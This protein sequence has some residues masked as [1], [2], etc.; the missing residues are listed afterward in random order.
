[1]PITRPAGLPRPLLGEFI[2]THRERLSPEEV[3]LPRGV[4]RRAKGLRREE[5]AQLCGISPTWLTWIEQGRTDSLSSRTLGSLALALRLTLAERA[6]LFNLAAFRD[7][8]AT[9]KPAPPAEVSSLHSALQVAAT[10]IKSAAYVLDHSWTA[11][12]W[13]RPAAALFVGWLGKSTS[14][15]N[16]LNY[17]FLDPHARRFVVGWSGRAERLVAEFR[18][19]RSSRLED[20]ATR[21]QVETLRQASSDFDRFWREQKVLN[22]EGGER[23]FKH[24]TRGR[25]SYQQLTLRV[26]QA[27][28]LKLVMLM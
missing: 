21:R 15:R 14:E 2:R 22:R 27:D 1:M 7:A 16:L 24:P 5:L 12:A 17:T 28:D 3:G 18:A 6:Y 8:E 25:L 10:N 26:A 20:P 19:D 13:N 11:V 9:S 23:V 4:R